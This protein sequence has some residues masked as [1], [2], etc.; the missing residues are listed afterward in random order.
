MERSLSR[1]FQGWT[2]G[3]S[4]PLWGWQLP[5][6]EALGVTQ[7]EGLEKAWPSWA[8]SSPAILRQQFQINPRMAAAALHR[9]IYLSHFWSGSASLLN[10]NH[11]RSLWAAGKDRLLIFQGC[12]ASRPRPGKEGFHERRREDERIKTYLALSSELIYL[13]F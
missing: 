11:S 4:F 7:T 6:R 3:Q 8:A 12:R 2:A 1:I 9:Q 5:Q 13:F 10:E